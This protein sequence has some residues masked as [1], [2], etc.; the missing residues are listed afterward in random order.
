MPQILVYTTVAQRTTCICGCV[1]HSWNEVKLG[2]VV[3]PFKLS[4][5]SCSS[6]KCPFY[7]LENVAFSVGYQVDC[8]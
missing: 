7:L 3:H 2:L 6:P 1:R 8:I 5:C 4:L